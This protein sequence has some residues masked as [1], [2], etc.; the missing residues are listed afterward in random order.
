[1]I[2]HVCT[3]KEWSDQLHQTVFKPAS[4]DKEHFVHCCLDSQL[5]GVLER[6]FPGQRDLLLLC[7][8]EKVL[9]GKVLYEA[10][11]NGEKFPHVFGPIDREAII[12]IEKIR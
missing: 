12:Q 5:N 10:G 9:R 11:P 2:L 3:S 4:F 6:Y 1:M 8:D 7:I